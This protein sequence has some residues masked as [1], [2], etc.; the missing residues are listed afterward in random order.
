METIKDRMTHPVLSIEQDKTVK[1]AAENIYSNKV[2]SLLVTENGNYIGIITKTDLMTRVLI[3]D[4]DAKTIKVS[5]VMSSPLYTI[6]SGESL[7]AA[8][9][10]LLEKSIRHLTVTH[11]DEVVGILSIKDL[12]QNPS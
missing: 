10:M 12:Q 3:K 2:G 6:D 4:L 7:A 8:R 5:E 9:E 1:N 11:N